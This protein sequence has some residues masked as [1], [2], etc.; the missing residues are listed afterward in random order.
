MLLRGSWLGRSRQEAAG[1]GEVGDKG[2]RAPEEGERAVAQRARQLSVCDVHA[3]AAHRS[4]NPMHDAVI[5]H[6]RCMRPR[7]CAC[8]QTGWRSPACT[9]RCPCA[10]EPQGRG[11]V[12]HPLKPALLDAAWL[13][14]VPHHQAHALALQHAARVAAGADQ[15]CDLQARQW[16]RG[17]I[18]STIETERRR[19]IGARRRRPSTWGANYGGGAVPA[20]LAREPPAP[21]SAPASRWHR[22]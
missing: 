11:H 5:Q 3:P 20:C 10:P 1:S 21:G 16:R 17:M 2:R 19:P 8:S 22:L 4:R 18:N 13:V 6:R 14:D 15:G 12:A 7:A 9:H